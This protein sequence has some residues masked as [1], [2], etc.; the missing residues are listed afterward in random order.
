MRL[1]IT[2]ELLTFGDRKDRFKSYRTPNCLFNACLSLTSLTNDD[3]ISKEVQ[4]CFTLPSS[5]PSLHQLLNRGD[6]APIL[7]STWQTPLP[8]QALHWVLP[9]DL[10]LAP[11]RSLWLFSLLVALPIPHTSNSA[12]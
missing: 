2:S 11:L 6:Q 5:P 9:P 7:T 4:C 1:Y 12:S 3:R 8:E 10:P